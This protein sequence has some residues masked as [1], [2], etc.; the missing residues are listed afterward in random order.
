[1]S[2]LCCQSRGMFLGLLERCLSRMMCSACLIGASCNMSLPCTGG[3]LQL[4]PQAP[5]FHNA[6]NGI[7]TWQA[8]RYGASAHGRQ[9]PR[10]PSSGFRSLPT[11]WKMMQT[12]STC[13]ALALGFAASVLSCCLHSLM[14]VLITLKGCGFDTSLTP[15]PCPG[16]RQVALEFAAFIKRC[17]SDRHTP[18]LV[19]H[20]GCGFDFPFL[21]QEYRRVGL[22][23]PLQ[24]PYLDTVQLARHYRGMRK[25]GLVSC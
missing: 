23:V 25:N 5:F 15:R 14:P 11:R 8:A 24:W 22:E 3:L 18:V 6:T 10:W 4:E 2:L 7:T 16:C 20:N 9:A 13:H 17:C 21:V 19:A 12:P 1:M